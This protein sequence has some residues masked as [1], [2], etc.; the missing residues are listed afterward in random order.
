MSS[1]LSPRARNALAAL[2]IAGGAG[3]LRALRDVLRDAVRE[4][5]RI[6]ASAGGGETAAGG[7]PRAAAPKVAVDAVFA[8]RLA[9]I[10]KVCVPS[11]FCA[12]AGLIYAQTALL[13]ARTLLTDWASRIEGAVGRYIIV[14]DRAR[15]RRLL[16]LFC[17]VAVP[18]SVVNAGL[19]YLQ[20]RIKARCS[21]AFF[22]LSNFFETEAS[23][24]PP[25]SPLPTHRPTTS[26]PPPPSPRQLAFVRRLTLH[27]HELYCSN[28]AYYAAS[29]L[30]G[31]SAPDQR[32]TEDVDKFA[33]AASELYSYTFKPLLDVALFTRSLGRI[34]GYR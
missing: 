7:K 20:R 9:N 15:L 32:L 16:G 2:V 13:V 28:R 24:P 34:M 23:D 18:A 4:Q 12:E 26:N 31:L 14:R 25:A 33:S 21:R 30:G 22:V 6:V 5:Q 10:L 29:W 17:A 3:G 27:L 8:G 1:A 11:P 19:K